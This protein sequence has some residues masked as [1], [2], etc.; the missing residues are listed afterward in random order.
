MMAALLRAAFPYLLVAALA[1]AASGGGTWLWKDR[2]RAVLV[3][4]WATLEAERAT[5]AADQ[6]KNAKES[7]D[8]AQGIADA[9]RSLPAVRVRC[10]ATPARSPDVPQAGGGK[11]GGDLRDS[12][13]DR[14]DGPR[15]REL[16]AA[17]L[18]NNKLAGV[19]SP[20]AAR[21]P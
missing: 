21:S 13:V 7:Q 14:D 4:G 18:A 19:P 9:V 6:T 3:A 12:G 2:Q 10:E 17:A 16:A 8:V 15:L 20:Y 11:L 5:A 1:G